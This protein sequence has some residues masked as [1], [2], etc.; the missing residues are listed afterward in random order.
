MKLLSTKK[1][2]RSSLGECPLIAASIRTT[3][4]CN[5]GCPHCYTGGGSIL[6]NELNLNE[7]KSVIDQLSKLKTFYIFFTGGEPFVR[8]DI[9]DILRYTDDKGIG[10]S[11]STN[12]QNVNKQLLEK[13]KDI[14]FTLFQIS[15]EGTEKI[16]DSLIKKGAWIKAIETVKLAKSILKKNIGVGT[17]IMKE[18]WMVLDK[19]LE[20]TCK[21]GADIFSLMLLIIAG[22]A[23][24]SMSP[25]PEEILESLKLV[26]DKYKKIQHKIQ[27]AKNTTIT[28]ALLPKEWRG[29]ELYK[30]FAPCSFPYCLG[31]SADGKVA[32]CDGLFDY[33]EMIVGNIREKP[34]AD[35][36]KK[37]NLL[38]EIRKVDPSDLKGVCKKCI[39]KEYCGGGCRA[40]TY[41]KYK[42]F[43]MPDPV[44]QSVY[45]KEL[46][47]K[48]CLK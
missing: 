28:P 12:G 47:P 32:P 41:I 17:V 19:I 37:S 42:D 31:I 29:K 6:S 44:C 45:E 13:L 46:F 33:N 39:Y 35:I 11:I 22:R 27:F 26:F 16:H 21:Q 18:N 34:L 8:K 40:F 14:N 7:M 1:Q 20:E 43:T 38:K 3:N 25:F 48:E 30:T 36:W 23:N 4:A 9:V 10:I 24:D 15:I 2:I 5:L